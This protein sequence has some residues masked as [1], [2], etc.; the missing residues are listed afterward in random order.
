MS[1]FRFLLEISKAFFMSAASISVMK[2]PAIGGIDLAQCSQVKSVRSGSI[3]LTIIHE[4]HLTSRETFKLQKNA[5]LT[6]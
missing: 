3:R 1:D 4:R 6:A 5:A 2:Q